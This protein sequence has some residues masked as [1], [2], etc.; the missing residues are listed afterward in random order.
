MQASSTSQLMMA[1]RQRQQ[2]QQQKFH[3][4]QAFILKAEASSSSSAPDERKKKTTKNKKMKIKLVDPSKVD[5]DALSAAFDEMARK[6]GFDDGTAFYADDATFEDDFN[7]D[8]GD[9]GDDDFLDFGDDGPSPGPGLSME[10]RISAAQRDTDMGRVSA[11]DDVGRAT[12]DELKKLGFKQER[13]PFNNDETPR[14]EEFKIITD[15][16][17][18][19]ACGSKFQTNSEDKP[20]FLPAAKY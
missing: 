12:R 3:N 10:E 13:N 4:K 8:L 1:Q 20:G 6:E 9:E 17:I 7:Y 16:M 11:P 5:V 19:S 14:K 15:A 2:Q 18:C